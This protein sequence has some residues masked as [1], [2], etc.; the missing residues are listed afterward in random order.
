MPYIDKENRTLILPIVDVLMDS[1]TNEGDL[2]YTITLL[3][4]MFANEH[5]IKYSTYNTIVG[6]LECVKQEFYRMDVSRYEDIKI[7]ENG[8]IEEELDIGQMGIYDKGTGL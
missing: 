2:N 6:V 3:C 4:K 7:K 5:G 1:I 8:L